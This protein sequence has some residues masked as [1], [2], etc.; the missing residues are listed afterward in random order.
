LTDATKKHI[1]KARRYCAQPHRG[2][3]PLPEGLSSPRAFA[4]RRAATKWMNGTVLH[5]CFL[6]RE[7]W[8]WPEEQRSVVR[9][10]FGAWKN[11]GV[12]LKFAEVADENEAEI[13]VG[14]LQDGNS[15]SYVGTENLHYR[16]RGRTMNFGWDLTTTWGRATAL[17]E[18]GHALGLEHEHQNPLSGIV[19]NEEAVYE[20]FERTND[21]NRQKTFDNVIARFPSNSIEGS[22]WDP[23]SIM[24]Y[25]FEPGLIASPRPFDT[26][27]IGEN[28]RLSA[29][30]KRWALHWYPAELRERQ[31]GAMSVEALDI[32]P[33]S[34]SNFTFQPDKTDTYTVR[35]VG[36]SDSRI[37]VFEERG[38]EPRHFAAAD[39]AG[40]AANAEIT[41][42]FIAG[43]RY[44]VRVRTA[45]AEG[46]RP[47]GL[48][49]H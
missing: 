4:I 29:D 46:A 11:L 15:W 48:L 9:D 7:D 23:A 21:W 18:I 14:R 45:F 35:T 42:K 40:T 31:I 19:W 16:D 30:D 8:D 6:T 27:G 12:G 41:A 13:L 34:Q 38:G 43:R 39:D 20:Y 49:V 47:V 2:P 10:A 32:L 1:E 33:G 25:P 24:H 5:Y 3:A 44:Y 26:T 36:K 22:R 28:V 37:V 17:H